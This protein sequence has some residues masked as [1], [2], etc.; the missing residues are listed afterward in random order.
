[1]PQL[2]WL[3]CGSFFILKLEAGKISGFSFTYSNNVLWIST[4][5]E[6]KCGSELAS[7]VKIL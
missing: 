1:M 2:P 4:M 7:K 6:E 5:L 3:N